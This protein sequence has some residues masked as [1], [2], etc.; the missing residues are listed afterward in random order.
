MS[1]D[2]VAMMIVAITILWG[3]LGYSLIRL[4]RHDAAVEDL[5]RDL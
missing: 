5:R 1:A 2:A 3:G 4:R